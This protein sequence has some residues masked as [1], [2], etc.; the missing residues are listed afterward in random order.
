MLLKEW[1]R[2]VLLPEEP[3][4]RVR[5]EL[6]RRGSYPAAD[7]W[8]VPDLRFPP[9]GRVVRIS[10]RGKVNMA[11]RFA[12]TH[13]VGGNAQSGLPWS[14]G[15]PTA[16]VQVSGPASR[17]CLRA[18]MDSG[19]RAEECGVMDVMGPFCIQLNAA[20]SRGPLRLKLA[21]TPR[22]TVEFLVH[23]SR[24]AGDRNWK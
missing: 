23:A 20:R 1:K 16:A 7:L 11:V 19:G 22:R 3:A 24:P 9:S 4:Y 15:G 8:T 14:S 5:L 18:L 12:L 2:A 17:F 21:L 10:R 13:L 6:A